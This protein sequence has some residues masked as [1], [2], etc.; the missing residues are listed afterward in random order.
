MQDGTVTRLSQIDREPRIGRYMVELAASRQH[1]ELFPLDDAADLDRM[2]LFYPDRP[3]PGTGPHGALMLEPAFRRYRHDALIAYQFADVHLLGGDGVI[4]LDSGV[5]KDS[6]AGVSAWQAASNVEEARGSDY[7]RLK[8]PMPVARWHDSG[9]CAIGFNGAWRNHGHWLLQCVPK[10]YAFSL[11]RR[12]FQDLK[13]ALPPPPPVSAVIRTLQLLGI[14][15]DAILPV[16]PD[17]ATGFASAILLPSFDLWSVTSFVG[18]AA[19]A[20]L[21]RLP[22]P[23]AGA[24]PRPDKIYIH[25]TAAPR[26]VANFEAIRPLLA[27]Y[28]FAVVSFEDMDFIEQVATMQAARHVISEHG[29][30]TT[31]IL[32]C[33]AGARVLQLFNPFCVEPTFWSI[34][35]RRALD[36]GYLIGAHHV[37]ASHPEATWNS[38][39]I[40]PPEQLEEAIRATLRLPPRGGAIAAPPVAPAAPVA[41][42]AT[43]TAEVRP[44]PTGGF[45]GIAEPIFEVVNNPARL[46]R[47]GR[48]ER[49]PL[50]AAAVPPP[51]RPMLNEATMPPEFVAEHYAYPAPTTVACYAVGRATLW[52][53]GFVTVGSQYVAMPDCLPGYFRDDFRPGAPPLHPMFAGAIGRADVK[54]LA[55]DRP[56]AVATHPNLSYGHFLL[57]ALP[58]LWLLAVLRE[59]GADLPLALSHTL[60]DTVK[61]FARMLHAEADILWY[62][63]ASERVQAPAIVL[64]A[65]LH[66]EYNFHPALNLMVRDLQRRL[67]PPDA[68][69]PKL[70]YLAR[71]NFGDDKLENQIEVEPAMRALGFAIVRLGDLTPD[72]QLRL[73]AAARVVVAEYGDAL[74]AALFAPPGTR[75]VAIN[76]ANHYQSAIARLRGH[77]IAYVPPADGTFRHWRLTPGL[78]P[79]WRVDVALLVRTVQEMMQG[80]G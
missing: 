40:V 24:P 49:L 1:L 41:L 27:R 47:S 3:E 64:P 62:D 48:N 57:E 53:T 23:A 45:A 22:P 11:L 15:P 17:E 75:V 70:I 37:T 13:V 35:S 76:F 72:Q 66:T 58:R 56:V 5:V 42:P 12:R 19:D 33:R 73:L 77:R 52:S 51:Q 46:G 63:G 44:D 7:L 54:T 43:S 59:F 20:M 32:F 55:L 65:M 80:T 30:A 29:A 74:H 2:P 6:L 50:F 8:R 61:A 28:G 18:N 21:A 36:Y 16:A 25:R 71:P 39:Y 38:D 10:L 26:N 68:R 79:T 14:G 34:A 60:S 4:V 67:P 69:I 9:R 78:S 31:N